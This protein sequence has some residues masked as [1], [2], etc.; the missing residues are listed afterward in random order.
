MISYY[1]FLSN[2]FLLFALRITFVCKYTKK[3]N[4]NQKNMEVFYAKDFLSYKII[5]YRTATIGCTYYF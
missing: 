5:V 2:I 4:K 3:N 1:Q